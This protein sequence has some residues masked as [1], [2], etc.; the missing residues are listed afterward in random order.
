MVAGRTLLDC[1]KKTQFWNKSYRNEKNVDRDYPEKNS[2]PRVRRNSFN[3]QGFSPKMTYDSRGAS[4][5][6]ARYN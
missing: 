1:K 3:G 2:R 5:G 4:C 6:Q